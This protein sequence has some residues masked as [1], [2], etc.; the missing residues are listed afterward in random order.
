M[1]VGHMAAAILVVAAQLVNMVVGQW[2]ETAQ[3][4]TVHPSGVVMVDNSTAKNHYVSTCPFTHMGGNG[5]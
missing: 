1:P 5:P 4:V 2:D 3:V